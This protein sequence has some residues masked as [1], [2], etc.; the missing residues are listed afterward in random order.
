MA[1]VYSSQNITLPS[2]HLLP[3][4]LVEAE[5]EFEEFSRSFKFSD[6]FDK[7]KKR[8]VDFR[9]F[10]NGLFQ[11][12]GTMSVYFRHKTYL[13]VAYFFF[14]RTKLFPSLIPHPSLWDG[15]GM[16]EG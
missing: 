13:N 12:E 16:G 9:K 2:T 15:G 11:A 5:K 3:S 8:P 10:I 1:G 6:E 7:F 4:G 14:N